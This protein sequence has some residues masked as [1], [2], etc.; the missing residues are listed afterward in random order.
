[1][2][3]AVV[4]IHP[5]RLQVICVVGPNAVLGGRLP[6][7]MGRSTEGDEALQ[8]ACRKARAATA[9][10]MAVAKHRRGFGRRLSRALPGARLWTLLHQ[11]AYNGPKFLQLY[12]NEALEARTLG[13]LRLSSRSSST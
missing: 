5:C 9:G 8:D 12:R 10:C 13:Q 2:P 7:L 6:R 1:M 11:S 3:C 4:I